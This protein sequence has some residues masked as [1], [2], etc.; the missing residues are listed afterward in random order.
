MKKHLFLLSYLLSPL[1]LGLIIYQGAPI[2]YSTIWS[3]LGMGLG[4]FA[5]TWVQWQFVISARPKW[6]EKN[7]G[8]DFLY[9]FH[10][11]MALVIIAFGFLHGQ[12]KG[13]F[14]R[15]SLMTQIGSISIALMAAISAMTLLLMVKSK[16]QR[17]PIIK[18]LVIKVQHTWFGRYEWQKALHRIMV[19]PMILTVIHV[20]MTSQVRQSLWVFGAYM[21]YFIF[22]FGHYLYYKLI[23]TWLL[24]D[25]PLK[26]VAIHQTGSLVDHTQMWH[27][28]LEPEDPIPYQPG[29]FGFFRFPK[30]KKIEEHPFTI[31]SGGTPDTLQITA[32]SLGDFTEDLAGLTVGSQ[33]L[34]DGPYGVFSYKLHP[35]EKNILLI[36][37]GVGITPMMAMLRHMA[38]TDSHIPV[39]LI[40]QMK[41]LDEAVFLD[42][43]KD[44]QSQLP[45]LTL[46]LYCS[47]E[48]DIPETL[49]EIVY[50]GR[51]DF[52]NLQKAVMQ[53][54][55]LKKKTGTYLCGPSGFTDHI[56]DYLKSLGLKRHQIHQEH[57]SY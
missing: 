13:M 34:M 54:A 46:E 53:D 9:R 51:V 17:L 32:K 31:A 36:A 26:V 19:V 41:Q 3:V 2:K 50:P 35:R 18:G 1:L 45:S 29:Q 11:M 43:L 12:L 40:W 30:A 55:G 56:V 7:I 23:K 39:T 15:E 57:F 28:S 5:F 8:M 33:L 16:W 24:Y 52:E 25:N 6:L 27:M 44:L 22:G 48:D 42:E 37:A 38:N 4:A 20:L 21:T 14:F 10:G 47:R 49:S